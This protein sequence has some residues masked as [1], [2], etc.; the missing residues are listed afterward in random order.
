MSCLQHCLQ[1]ASSPVHDLAHQGT[2]KGRL[3][4]RN[5]DQ[6]NFSFWIGKFA[7]CCSVGSCTPLE[8]QVEDLTNRCPLSG[9]EKVTLQTG[10]RK[11][12]TEL[13]LNSLGFPDTLYHLGFSTTFLPRRCMN[14][15]KGCKIAAVSCYSCAAFNKC[16]CGDRYEPTKDIA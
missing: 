16:K 8:D 3:F 4:C 14:S 7:V 11:P 10:N 13:E 9:E 15:Q 1:A 2:R 5:A 6:D 12:V